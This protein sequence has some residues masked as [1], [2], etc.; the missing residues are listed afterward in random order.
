[1]LVSGWVGPC[2]P[3]RCVRSGFFQIESGFFCFGLGYRVGKGFRSKSWLVLGPWVIV[4]QKLWLVSVVLV[5]PGRVRFFQ[6]G[7]IRLVESGGPCSGIAAA[8]ERGTVGGGVV[9]ARVV[10]RSESVDASA[11][12]DEP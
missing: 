3:I 9:A 7:Q 1:M 11:C 8:M 10:D 2:L 4:G 12:L 5:R 6:I